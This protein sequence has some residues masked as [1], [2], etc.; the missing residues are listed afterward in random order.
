[1]AIDP[2]H[3]PLT[4]A[5]TRAIKASMAYR[6]AWTCT[7]GAQL[8]IRAR[9]TRADGPSNYQGVHTAQSVRASSVPASFIGHSIVAHGDLNWSG[10]A[11]EQGWQTDPIRC[12]A[13]QR[14]LTVSA[15]KD[16]RRA[17]LL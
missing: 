6:R 1:M 13:C 14:R 16:A 9:E 12:P 17:G 7:C 2:T 10:L 11:E 4:P 3:V 8:R 15:F 5:E